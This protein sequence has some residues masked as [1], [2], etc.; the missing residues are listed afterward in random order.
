[1][2]VAGTYSGSRASACRDCPAGTYNTVPASD[3]CVACAAGRAQSDTAS[4]TCTACP[5]GRAQ[6]ATGQTSC[7]ICEPG[8]ANEDGASGAT[9]CTKCAAGTFQPRNGSSVCHNCTR[10]SYSSSTGSAQCEPCHAGEFAPDVGAISCLSC[11]SVGGPRGTGGAGYSSTAGAAS[12]DKASPDYYLTS[13]GAAVLC[14]EGTDCSGSGGATVTSM[15]VEYGWYRFTPTS[16]AAYECQ[17]PANCRGGNGTGDALCIKG[18]GGPLCDV[19]EPT[20]FLRE[21]T[22]RC[23]SCT[24]ANAWLGPILFVLFAG[25]AAA[26]YRAYHQ[27]VMVWYSAN[28][29]WVAALS[30]KAG[31]VFV[32]LQIIL[33]I[34]SN[35]SS[36]GGRAMPTPYFDFLAALSF[37]ALDVV[38]FL[39]LKCASGDDFDHLDSLLVMTLVPLA[40]L[41]AA[42]AGVTVLR[43]QKKQ[44]A[45]RR[46]GSSGVSAGGDVHTDKGM[47]KRDM[48][49]Y[50]LWGLN[51]VLPT[52]SRQICRSFRCVEYDDSKFT[53]LAADLSISCD[54]SE[55][56][57]MATFAVAMMFVYPMGTP[58]LLFAMLLPFR[59]RFSPPEA[60]HD[61]AEAIRQREADTDLAN[62]PIAAFAMNFR[63][64]FWWYETFN[65]AR[66]LMLTT[67]VLV[68][69]SLAQATV[70]VVFV[71]ITTLVIERES[72]PHMS[73]FLCNFVHVCQWQVVIFVLFSLL[74]DADMTSEAGAVTISALL[75]LANICMMAV[76]FF[77]LDT[78]L[79]RTGQLLG[80]ART[81]SRAMR[82]AEGALG[83]GWGPAPWAKAEPRI[84]TTTT[85]SFT[86][87]NPMAAGIGKGEAGIEMEVLGVE[88]E[89]GGAEV[90][91]AEAVVQVEVE[92][93]GQPGQGQGRAPASV[94]QA[95][96]PA[97]RRGR[98]ASYHEP[99]KFQVA[100]VGAGAGVG[101]G[102]AT[103]SA[104]PRLRRG[105]TGSF[106][107]GMID[108]RSGSSSADSV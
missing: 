88:L 8:K 104:R 7:A 76:I 63:P 69:D 41:G 107:P 46:D 65:M 83:K 75:M 40:V 103:G 85:D 49:C 59:E 32:T 62:E 108:F 93:D 27:Q 11:A 52:I 56:T 31:A 36:V 22:E 44:A 105:S 55:Y 84:S 78:T 2:C 43:E 25:V 1:M 80:R 92:V 100:G 96:P 13:D 33:L 12:C 6:S 68:C 18:A 101:T 3:T 42:M 71:S 16:T 37:L 58:L 23:E 29:D 53:H 106:G 60:R 21:S 64:R 39:P 77:D 15:S 24:V 10:G 86:V 9:S 87:E 95:G 26:V 72:S 5:E 81:A 28:E 34:R 70:F 20:Y 94:L 47:R 57:G 99:A 38:Q 48:V 4:T 102:A 50:F 82:G 19:C 14:P 74:L 66:R 98:R 73:K 51:L 17:H 89:G 35:H 30:E 79:A 90:D 97:P 45:K 61:E 67:V 91:E 54:S